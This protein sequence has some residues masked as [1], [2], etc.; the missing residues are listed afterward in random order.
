MAT[1]EQEAPEDRR[2][3]TLWLLAAGAASLLIP[4]AGALYIHWRDNPAGGSPTARADVFERREGE[5]RKITP[6]QTAVVLAPPAQSRPAPA[7]AAAGGSSLDFIKGGA[8]MQGKAAEPKAAAAP[9][10]APAAA[11]PPA[12]AAPAKAAAATAKK[13]FNAPRLQPTRG[14]THL[15]S[16]PG[17]ANGGAAPGTSGGQN[18]QG[19]LNNLPPGSENNPQIQAYLKSQQG[20]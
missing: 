7:A 18:T 19:L 3:K 11:A 20:H 8:D 5:E 12:V 14:F 15:G 2:K 9:A 4:L 1:A 16:T 13:P 17:A 10:P 6:S